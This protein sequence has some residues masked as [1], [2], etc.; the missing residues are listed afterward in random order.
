MGS[1]NPLLQ[2]LVERLPQ[3]VDNLEYWGPAELLK[4]L[5]HAPGGQEASPGMSHDHDHALVFTL[6][7]QTGISLLI[8]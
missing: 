4:A 6:E 7:T 1:I 3:S 2:R 5:R 8:E